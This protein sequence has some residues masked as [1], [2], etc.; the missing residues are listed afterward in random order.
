MSLSVL[1]QLHYATVRRHG[2]PFV[3]A[4]LPGMSLMLVLCLAGCDSPE[5]TPEPQPEE[6]V[7]APTP[8]RPATPEPPTCEPGWAT[9]FT[10]SAANLR[11]NRRAL[12][13]LSGDDLEGARD[14]LV[15]L[16]ADAPDYDSARFNLACTLA[17]LDR[18]DE[19]RA[20]LETLLCRDLPTNLP[21]A[22]SDDDLRGL[23]GELD[24][25][26]ERL[27]PRYRE[28]E[29]TP[30]VAFGKTEVGAGFEA[31]HLHWNQS[32]LWTGERFVPAAPRQQARRRGGERPLLASALADE[33]AV[34]VE[35]VSSS[36]EV[37]HLPPM[38]VTV[39]KLFEGEEITHRSYDLSQKEYFDVVV[40]AVD[41]RAWIGFEAHFDG[42]PPPRI[43]WVDD[44]S[45]LTARPDPVLALGM[46]TWAPAAPTSSHEVRRQRELRVGEHSFELDRRHRAM[47]DSAVL[48][49]DPLALV[50]SEAVGDCGSPD[51][52]VLELV[53]TRAGDTLWKAHGEGQ[54]LAR[55]LGDAL[56]M[57]SEDELFV[58]PDPTRDERNALPPGFGLSS[59]WV[60]FNPMC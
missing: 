40:G 19:A 12:S 51:R 3:G 46:Q 24:A 26:A 41:G 17:R 2:V 18:D 45:P 39:T 10:P 36:A 28:T 43:E 60:A 58:L 1:A 56:W 29:G 6:P 37:E 4:S 48:A 57:Q 21:R 50:V 55:F 59:T 15:A 34:L 27:L 11:Q 9:P 44:R 8:P 35:G 13:K 53:D 54:V 33:V 31:P 22:R 49:S 23:R 16:L 5:S 7:E 30:L 32:G 20:E 14:E 42:A 38:K 25:I 47:N 52:W